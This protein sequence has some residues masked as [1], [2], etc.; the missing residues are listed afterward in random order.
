MTDEDANQAQRLAT[1]ALKRLEAE[2]ADLAAGHLD[3]LMPDPQPGGILLVKALF[4]RL[5]VAGFT[6]VPPMQAHHTGDDWTALYVG[7]SLAVYGSTYRS[8]E[9]IKALAGAVELSGAEGR[10]WMLGAPYGTNTAPAS[11]LDQVW[12]YR[13]QRLDREAQAED[14]R[15]K[16]AAL[17]ERADALLRGDEP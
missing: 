4:E 7:G 8:D 13:A 2:L 5:T 12:A 9:A 17:L 3:G 15:A 1:A 6:V 16:A 14:L 11:T 10:D